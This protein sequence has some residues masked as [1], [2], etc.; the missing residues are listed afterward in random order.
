M[1]I[2][3]KRLKIGSPR[4]DNE[5][6]VQMNKNT[7]KR[8]MA[9]LLCMFTITASI[10]ADAL[11]SLKEAQLPMV[12]KIISA[13]CENGAFE[14]GILRINSGKASARIYF[15]FVGES[16]I[17]SYN[18][19]DDADVSIKLE[20][21]GSV[22][23]THFGKGKSTK[24]VKFPVTEP[25]EWKTMTVTASAPVTFLEFQLVADSKEHD[26]G[27]NSGAVEVRY[28]ENEKALQT[29]TVL[30]TSSPI[31]LIRNAKRYLCTDHLD[32]RPAVIDGV[33][34]LPTEIVR[35]ILRECIEEDTQ[36]NTV[37]VK[38]EE[39][40]SL[41]FDETGCT[42]K[43]FF[44]EKRVENKLIKLGEHYCL[45]I[46]FVS[47]AFD[48]VVEY[49]DGV[50]IID[51]ITRICEV[52]DRPEVITYA[53]SAIEVTEKNGRTIHV[54][55]NHK[56]ASDSNPGSEDMP[57]KTINA[58]TAVADAGDTVIVHS[59]NYRE[60]VTFKNDGVQ[61]SP[62]ILKGADGE[63]V[64]IDATETVT[65]L[66]AYKN[67]M[68]I[69]SVPY[70]MP[71][72][73]NQLWINKEVYAEGRHP[74]QD[75]NPNV[76]NVHEYLDLNPLWPTAGDIHARSP[77]NG[78]VYHLDS[79]TTLNQ[80]EPNYW[81]GGVV[82]MLQ[83]EGW[84]STIG[85]IEESGYGWL[86]HSSKSG[87]PRGLSYGYFGGTKMELP[88][89]YAFITNHINTV[90]VPGE[91]Y[92]DSDK[93]ILYIIPPEDFNFDNDVITYKARTLLVDLTRKNHI[94]IQN[95]KGFGGSIT[96]LDSEMCIISDCDLRYI[97][98]MIWFADTRSG[99]ITNASDRTENN[100]QTK[101]EAGIYVGGLNNV[102]RDCYLYSSAVTG[103]Y[104]AGKYSY[105][106]NNYIDQ[107]SYAGNG[108][109]SLYIGA[110]EWKGRDYPR[111]GHAIYYNSVRKSARGPLITNNVDVWMKNPPE[112]TRFIAMDIAYNDFYEGGVLC[113]RDGGL[114]YGHGTQMGDNII[115]TK[116]HKNLFWDY[117]VYDAYE[118]GMYYDAG[119]TE[120]E[121]FCNVTF[122][123]NK[124]GN[125]LL[126][127]YNEDRPGQTMHKVNTFDWDYGTTLYIPEGKQGLEASDYPDGFVYQSGS[128]L[129]DTGRITPSKEGAKAY[130]FADAQL[131]EGLKTDESGAVRPSSAEDMAIFKNVDFGDGYDALRIAFK[132]NYYS[133]RDRIQ[134]RLD[135]ADG[136]I[137]AV[138]SLTSKA[139]R[140]CQTDTN[141][142]QLADVSGVHD[143][144]VTFPDIKSVSYLSIT[145]EYMKSMEADEGSGS[146]TMIPCEG[147]VMKG[148]WGT[149]W[150]KREL[151]PNPKSQGLQGSWG[152]Y[153]VGFE[154]VKL[155]DNYSHVSITYGTK[156][157]YS[158]GTCYVYVDSMDKE[159]AAV[160]TLDGSNWSEYVTKTVAIK[161]R[162]S[163]TGLHEIYLKFDGDGNC[164]D[165]YDVTFFYSADEPEAITKSMTYNRQ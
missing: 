6:I 9:I 138:K 102:I 55:Q 113:G 109:G 53:K 17:I 18:A 30:S 58:A 52:T 19:E 143:L 63:D 157:P 21:T 93:K 165:I 152:G 115:R 54:A 48:K 78:G 92:I 134:I 13:E 70:T 77:E 95:I 80:E 4:K 81:K 154:G 119:V 50:I 146:K 23:N 3:S 159:P 79:E 39:N 140:M 71:W 103:L 16:M 7:F 38:N 67:N 22:M 75:N 91:W 57:Y 15:P 88:G 136:N 123:T 83:H 73:M 131:S 46:R 160:F 89:D 132:G 43:N 139:P 162:Q 126:T 82:H 61:G 2:I 49:R 161:D 76:P 66:K 122:C 84:R 64:T 97:S 158:G 127:S 151:P 28:S 128:T 163:T 94:K 14:D 20:P 100:G 147:F 107:C 24:T 36:N 124:I 10:P 37:V 87:E 164:A 108:T 145:P 110:E 120:M 56:N 85:I 153:W 42:V 90:D 74:N 96:M 98:H 133:D 27:S 137:I 59:G 114:F 12:M 148:E 34:Y 62:I 33:T 111:G 29:A 26:Y 32:L 86:R 68:Y 47:E 106:Y 155:Y 51:E 25:G 135:S 65:D 72:N 11:E 141:T 69:G 99:Y 31:A 149:G 35:E 41:T 105:V 116:M 45:P 101:G 44:G 118:G 112:A 104:L 5:V 121:G 130:Y 125:Y 117:Y 40:Y 150:K 144:Y 129:C 8:F 60:T 1:Q 142:I 156:Q